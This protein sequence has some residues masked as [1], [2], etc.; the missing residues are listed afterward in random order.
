MDEGDE[1]AER[2][3]EERMQGRQRKR[4]QFRALLRKNWIVR[5]RGAIKVASVL[6]LLLPAVFFVLMTIPRALLADQVY[7]E[8]IYPSRELSAWRWGQTCGIGW[9]LGAVG[10][11]STRL[12][13]ESVKRLVCGSQYQLPEQDITQPDSNLTETVVD[14]AFN[15]D[16]SVVDA[17]EATSL[18]E[19]FLRQN[20]QNFL[21]MQTLCNL[22][23]LPPSDIINSLFILENATF[24]RACSLECQ[25]DSECE[26]S[27]WDRLMSGD[28]PLP[29][30]PEGKGLL[31]TH[32][33]EMDAV[34]VA[35]RNPRQ[36]LAV[37]NFDKQPET[38][39][40][41]AYTIRV[42][43]SNLESFYDDNYVGPLD[44][45]APSN[46][47]ANTFPLVNVQNAVESA[48]VQYWT[49]STFVA[50]TSVKQ[51]PWVSY[52]I[53]VGSAI[54]AI[55]LSIVVS[56]SFSTSSVLVLKSVVQEK[57]LR[58]R[59]AMRVM[60]LTDSMFWLSWF[61]THWSSL[62][63]TSFICALIGI[64]PFPYSDWTVTLVFLLVWSVN[65]IAFNY[66]IS[67]FFD[68][69][70]LAATLGWFSYVLTITP[71]VA[72]HSLYFQGSAAWTWSTI[73][74]ASALHGWGQVLARLEVSQ[75]GLTWSTFSEN[76]S[77]QNGYFRARDILLITTC[78]ALVF[79][80]LA[81]Y[82]D[83]VWP[84]KHGHKRHPLFVLSARYW[85]GN[86]RRYQ[87]WRA[88]QS[89]AQ[90]STAGN[91]IQQSTRDEN[92]EP[93]TAEKESNASIKLKKLSKRYPGASELA[94]N[95]L[96]V[97]FAK[98][99]VGALL[100]QVRLM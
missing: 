64:Y 38:S 88:T 83:N 28:P 73:V 14:F 93:L 57:E 8:T 56:L 47:W 97:S 85:C 45:V 95:N 81:W 41:L 69:S 74:P 42:N 30:F 94:V 61:V 59:E 33:Q 9:Q 76:I 90:L 35:T 16:L 36:T 62:G 98:N 2:I 12:G 100:G 96:S 39:D 4:T 67:A 84:S 58:L 11:D 65:L 29:L 80:I 3:R 10:A 52:R 31:R 44:A 54:A 92:L 68:N 17:S 48:L 91:A 5:T 82:F 75:R 19:D 40:S 46:T 23:T 7:N 34:T 37:V 27:Q 24:S 20:P 53:N 51:Q 15:R 72:A 32:S 66:F 86:T 70:R 26:K 18:V 22:A 1:Q 60:G 89:P 55:F 50:Q 71:S 63:V 87:R 13:R 21:L 78:Q 79:G 25:R 49:N 6:E 77:P 99:E 43:G